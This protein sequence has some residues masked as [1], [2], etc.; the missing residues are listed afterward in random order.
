MWEIALLITRNTGLSF[1][2]VVILSVISPLTHSG[3]SLELGL[4]TDYIRE[5]IKMN[6]SMP[7]IQA[8][9]HADHHYGLYAGAWASSFGFEKDMPY[10]GDLYAG[11]YLP[12][13]QSFAIDAGATHFSFNNDGIDNNNYD[14]WF[15]NLIGWDALTLS[16]KKSN[17]FL[18]SKLPHQ[19]I[20][21]A[22][23]FNLES[24]SIDL[25]VAQNRYQKSS[26]QYNWGTRAS[27]QDYWHFKAGV[28]RSYKAWDYRINLHATSLPDN[29]ASG[30]RMDFSMS[31]YFELW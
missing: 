19:R 14:E 12:L 18:G 27:S 20:Q 24:F 2:F 17:N 11:W 6:D 9:L 22:Y 8:G 30:Y 13:T 31:R 23:T 25:F 7:A 10:E 1:F 21:L 16:Y 5:G 15:V 4:A 28:V 26:E 29:F 3:G